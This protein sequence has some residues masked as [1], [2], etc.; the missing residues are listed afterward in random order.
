MNKLTIFSRAILAIAIMLCVALPTLAHDFE[1]GGIYYNYLNNTAKTVEVTYKGSSYSDYSNEYTGSVTIP[2][3]VT[4][5]GTTYSVTKIGSYAF[6]NCDGLTSVT[7]PNS[8][9]SIGVGAFEVCTGLTSV[10]IPNSVTSIGSEAFEG[11]SG[12][13]SITIPNSVTSIDNRA[14]YNCSGLTS[15]TIP[16]SVT[17]IGSYAFYGCTGLTSVT[18]PNSVTTIGKYAFYGCTGLTSITIPN[19]VTSIGDRAFYKCTGLTSIVI[20]NSVTEIGNEAFEGT[21]WYNNLADGVIYNGVIYI[22]NVLYDYKG[23][24]PNGTSISVKDGTVSISPSAFRD[25]T[26][27]TSITIPNSVTSIGSSAFEGCTGLTSVTIGNSV[28]KIGSYAFYECTRLTSIVIPNSVTLIGSSAFS[29]CSGLT[30]VTIGNSVTTID[31]RTF[32]GCTGLTEVNIFDLSA[33]CKIDFFN[34]GANPIYYAKKLKLNGAEIKDLVIPNDITEIK[35]YA[36]YGCTGLTSITIPNSVTLIGSEAFWGCTGLT[37]IVVEEGN[38]KYDSRDNCNAIIET[39]TNTLILGCK[40][41]TIPN[42]VTSIGNSAFYGCTGLTSVTIPNSV[43]SIG[44]SA[45]GDCT[46]L[47]SVTIPNSV[48]SIGNSAFSG[49]TGLTS[50]TIPNSVTS[51]GYSAFHNC[52]GLTSITIPNS[53]TS[54]G[55][56]AFWGCDGLTSITIPN[57]VTSIGNHAFWG[58]TGLTSITIPNSVTSIGSWAFDDCTGL[59]ELIIEDGKETLSLGYNDIDEGLFYDCPLEKLYLGRNLSYNA[60][61]SYGYSPFYNKTKLK[62]VT[63]GNSVTSIG[64]SA[65]YGCSNL[66]ESNNVISPTSVKVNLNTLCSS[67]LVPCIAINNKYYTN[68]TLVESL[69]PEYNYNYDLGLQFKDNFILIGSSSFLTGELELTT[70]A[71]KAT[72]SSS[73]R[74]IATTNCDA[75][76]GTGFEWLRYDAPAEVPPNKGSCPIVDGML[77]GSLRGVRDD[78]YYKY[79]PFYTSASGKTYYG[80]WIAFFTGDANVY[81][82]PEVQTYS[83]YAITDNSVVVKGYALEGTDEITAQGFEYWKTGSTILPSSTENRM[84]VI[85]SGITMSATLANLE[86]NSTYKYRAF[87]TTAKGTIYGNEVEFETGEDPV[88][89]ESILIDKSATEVFEIARYDIHGRLLSKPSR[90]INIIIYSDGTTRKEIVKE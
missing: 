14:F 30:S 2:S 90:G 32:Y 34:S 75:T 63:I 45:F 42:S 78:A 9:T 72:S 20:P 50:V 67:N 62:E 33:W 40:N 68:N 86:Y 56:S 55:N 47:T 58:C 69:D 10:T 85:A 77:I 61:Q 3:S 19:S 37:S 84:T 22:N 41:S 60:T 71:A 1:V 48:T 11:C 73:V 28:T 53:V 82:E 76:A 27:L 87:V 36:F 26:G 29:G 49:C 57:S 66:I 52:T 4:Y 79:R 39:S 59:T 24:M 65:F 43:T 13:T 51:I 81:F 12:L 17:T 8:V 44:N 74:L 21:A 70:Q 18:I 15:V 7:I 88:G 80:E 5:S 23:S 83:D 6:Y 16:N 46:G 64:N 25:C 54:I 89:V 38:P 35:K 31:Y